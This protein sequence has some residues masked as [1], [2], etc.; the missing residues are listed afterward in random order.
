M[1]RERRKFDDT[2][3]RRFVTKYWKGS[4]NGGGLTVDQMAAKD[5]IAPSVVRRWIKDPRYG[6]RTAEQKGA[7]V[8]TKLPT[9]KR[10]A[11]TPR[12]KP[13]V[14]TAW[15]CPHCGGPIVV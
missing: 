1:A 15:Q 8:L 2:F 14:A 13:I 4:D 11:P 10:A 12:S 3:K 5:E 6:G 7:E 9:K